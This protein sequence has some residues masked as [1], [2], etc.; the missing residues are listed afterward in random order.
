MTLLAG[1]DEDIA[2]TKQAISP[3]GRNRVRFFFLTKSVEASRNN[4]RGLWIEPRTKDPECL[5]THEGSNPLR[6]RI[7]QDIRLR[8]VD[9]KIGARE[10]WD[11]AANTRAHRT[12]R[13]PK[14]LVRYRGRPC[15]G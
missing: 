13:E 3:F 6:E 5:R 7:P 2:A 12:L 10:F 4:W 9:S 8:A 1:G 14:T 11:R 15:E